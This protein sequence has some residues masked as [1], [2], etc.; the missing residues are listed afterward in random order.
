MSA[1]QV[2]FTISY[3]GGASDEQEIDFYDVAQ[4]LIG[5]QRSI[6]L[7]THLIFNGEII[8]QAPALKGAHVFAL[9]PEDGSWKFT[10]KVVGYVL[11]GVGAAAVAPRDTPL[12]HLVSS[13]YDYVVSENLGFHV[14]YDKTLGEQYEELKKKKPEIEVLPQSKFDALSEKCENAVL[15]MHRPIVESGTA[16]TGDITAHMGHF[17]HKF[18]HPL[19]RSTFEYIDITDKS[20]S[21]YEFIGKVSSYNVNTFKGRIYILD[22]KRPI[23]FELDPGIR[24]RDVIE[25]VTNS[26]VISGRI[27]SGQYK[28]S[29]EEMVRMLGLIRLLGFRL[30]ARSGRLKK[31]SV[32][33]VS[34]WPPKIEGG[35]S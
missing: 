30:C 17:V 33:E 5:F 8:T 12:G 23:P 9:P 2:S 34:E 20:D 7:T 16:V 18:K 6:A 31:I 27:R 21:T 14:D 15:N 35:E 26:L 10:A 3:S 28:D 13:A 11:A 32:V 22:E 24:N 4:A 19:N 1:H 25:Q 29:D